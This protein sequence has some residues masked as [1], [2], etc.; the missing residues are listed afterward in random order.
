[1]NICSFL[2]FEEERLSL[3]SFS[4]SF[5]LWFC[6]ALVLSNVKNKRFQENQQKKNS[7]NCFCKKGGQPIGWPPKEKEAA[8]LQQLPFIISGVQWLKSAGDETIK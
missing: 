3:V 8:G 6:Q 4:F 2:G 1:M 7:G 5:C